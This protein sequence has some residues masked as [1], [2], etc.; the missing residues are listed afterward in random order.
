MRH[1][2]DQDIVQPPSKLSGLCGRLRCCLRYEH[3][4][5]VQMATGAPTL[6]CSGCAIKGEKGIVIERNL[7]KGEVTIRSPEGGLTKVAAEDFTP[8]APPPSERSR[9]P[10]RRGSPRD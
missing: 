9:R 3:E 2:K 6:G 4:G 8:D 5:Y 7:L 10:S 1:A